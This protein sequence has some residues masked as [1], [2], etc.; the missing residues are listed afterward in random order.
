MIVSAPGK[1]LLC[2]EYAV[3]EGGHALV[4]AVDRFVH[5]R[6]VTGSHDP[7]AR[8]GPEVEATLEAARRAFGTFPLGLEFDVG[9]LFHDGT[10]LGLGSSA[11]CSAA[12]AALA[13]A[14][15]GHELQLQRSKD[16]VFATAFEGHGAVAP[17]GSGVD[18]AAST[19]GGF[20]LFDPDT[21]AEPPVRSVSP[22][23]LALSLVWTGKPVRTSDLVRQVRAFRYSQPQLHAQRFADLHTS[24]K[25]FTRAFLDGDTAAILE[26]VQEYCEAMRQLGEASGTPIVD[27]NL[28][29]IAAWA[30]AEGGAAKPCGAGG[31][32]VAVAFFPD[33][34][35]RDRFET[36]CRSEGFLPLGVA[37]GVPGVFL[38]DGTS[39]VERRAHG[40]ATDV[41][42]SP[43]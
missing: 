26:A 41:T 40:L 19:Y 8:P 6:H 21:G 42:T 5:V 23:S 36:H 4:A 20:L 14:T 1:A 10:K 24:N 37:W 32:D 34:Q 25:A 9:E 27:R 13:A 17:Q 35:A 11:A 16:L 30:A 29:A 39:V 38:H 28:R 2:G 31:G 3:L 43:S 15:Q 33:S 7:P 18:V 22:P 12:V